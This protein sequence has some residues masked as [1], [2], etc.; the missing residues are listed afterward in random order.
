M[1]VGNIQKVVKKNPNRIAYKVGDQSITYGELW[2]C[3]KERSEFLKCQGSSPVI[4][5]GNKE[6]NVVKSILS[7]LLAKRPY[8]PVGICTPLTR[9]K[10]IIDIT[11]STLILTDE[12]VDIREIECCKFD[13]LSKNSSKHYDN[14]SNIAYIIFTSGSTGEPKGVPISTDN[15]EN[16]INWINSLKPL[17]D[18]KNINVLNQASFS[19]DLSVADFYYSMSNGHTLCALNNDI[20]ENYNEFF[21]LFKEID[22]AVITPTLMKMCLLNKNFN[23]VEFPRFKC[24]YF[25]GELL[26]RKTAK[27]LLELFPNLSIINAYGPTEATSAIS[28]INITKEIVENEEIL[29]VGNIENFATNVEII[30]N[31]IVLKGKSVFS[32]YLDNIIGGYYSENNTNCYKTGDVGCIKNNKLY[33][34]GRKDSQVKYM[35]YRIELNDIEYNISNINGVSECAIIAKYN[36]NNTVRLIKA[37]VV[38]KDISSEYIRK[39]LQ[40]KI[41]DYMIPKTIKIIDKMP[42]NQ[43]GKTDRRALME[44]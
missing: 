21:R 40:N 26:E 6:L 44:L 14:N 27:K 23:E 5:Y 10:K 33:C 38:G 8:V 39:E 24:V 20:Q 3:A 37:F 11:N 43:N 19:F 13:E 18:Y 17:S 34:K 28:A 16:F 41:P 2:T 1:I 22:V 7:C 29:P 12:V 30:D 36:D 9:L 42:V 31:E 4:I 15:L 35:G 25:C 32:G